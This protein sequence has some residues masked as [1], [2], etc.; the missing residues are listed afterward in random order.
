MSVVIPTPASTVRVTASLHLETEQD[1]IEEASNRGVVPY[2][3]PAEGDMAS[4]IVADYCPAPD[5]SIAL[6]AR[7][8]R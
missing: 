2:Y 1:V 4:L 7:V 3:L 5:L 6:I 8:T